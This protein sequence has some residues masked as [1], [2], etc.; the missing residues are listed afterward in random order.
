M[1]GSL[2][3]LF[4]DRNFRMLFIG[5]ALSGVGQGMTMIGMPWYIARHYSSSHALGTIVAIGIVFSMLIGPYLGALIDRHKRKNIILVENVM[6][7]LGMGAMSAFGFMFGNYTLIAMGGVYLF[8]VLIFNLHFPTTYALAQESFAP[9]LY[10]SIS[11]ILEVVTQ[12]SAIAAGGLAGYILESAGLPMVFAIDSITYAVS[13]FFVQAFH[14]TPRVGSAVTRRYFFEEIKTSLKYLRSRPRF[15]RINIALFIPFVVCISLDI[16]DP[17][18]VSKTMHAPAS[19]FALMNALYAAGATSAGLWMRNF[20]RSYGEHFAYVT[21]F[22]AFMT[23]LLLMASLPFPYTAYAS[24]IVVGWCNA[25]I[26]VNRVAFVMNEVPV[27]L[28]GRVNTF[29]SIVG[30]CMR[31]AIVLFLTWGIDALGP[32]WCFV[33]MVG[34]LAVALWLY[35]SARS[36]KVSTV[37]V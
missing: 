9:E 23:V 13:F 14:Y 30:S 19:V 2:R 22:F 3:T 36:Y 7:F 1:T 20:A 37:N 11:G 26:R 35:V 34:A 10:G 28:I 16:I 24:I 27:E 29:F 12:T 32:Q 5:N 25:G 6:G 31:L 17:F 8:V 4:R 21:A 33:A 15:T 18:Y